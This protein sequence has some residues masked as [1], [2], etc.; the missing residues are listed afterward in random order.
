M[1]I[2]PSPADAAPSAELEQLAAEV[3]RLRP[4]HSEEYYEQRSEIVAGLMRLS[5]RLSG[6][7]PPMPLRITPPAAVRQRYTPPPPPQPVPPIPIPPATPRAAPAA[8]RRRSKRHRYPKPG[9]DP[10]Q[11]NLL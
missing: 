5:R 10:R 8:P 1:F 3:R 9:A 6:R 11:A 7:P 4:L 2:R